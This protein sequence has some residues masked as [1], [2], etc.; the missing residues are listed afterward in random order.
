MNNTPKQV[1]IDIP[2]GEA[3]EVTCPKCN[4]NIFDIIY[5]ILKI[6]KLSPHNPTNQDIIKPIPCFKCTNKKCGHILKP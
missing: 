4:N 5:K 1:K 2:A 6:S 3:T